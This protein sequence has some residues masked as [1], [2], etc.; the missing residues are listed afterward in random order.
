MENK[1]GFLFIFYYEPTKL[2][3][4]KNVSSRSSI[5]IIVVESY[6]KFKTYQNIYI[7]FL[8]EGIVNLFGTKI[9]RCLN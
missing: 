7:F 9:Q 8:V 2:K 4:K 5:F 3:K 6:L 1:R